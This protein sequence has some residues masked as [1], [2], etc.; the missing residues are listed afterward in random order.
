MSN[1]NRVIKM[2]GTLSS[3]TWDK[4]DNFEWTY[5]IDDKEVSAL[6]FY[7]LEHIKDYNQEQLRVEYNKIMDEEPANANEVTE[8]NMKL[9]LVESMIGEKNPFFNNGIVGF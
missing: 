7:N 4:H 9:S 6:V 3:D 5:W 2:K 1:E 8:W